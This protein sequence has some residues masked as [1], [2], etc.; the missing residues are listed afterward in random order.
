MIKKCIKCD[1]KEL[2]GVQKNGRV[3]SYCKKCQV[4]YAAIAYERKAKF[5]NEAK[6]KPCTDCG[7]IYPYYVMQFDHLG[8][9]EFTISHGRW[10]SLDKIKEEVAKCEVVCA[11]CHFERSWQ[12]KRSR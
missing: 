4:A 8:D 10:K 1:K 12:R 9:K 2:H 11:N 7:V 3:Q 6:N 5:L